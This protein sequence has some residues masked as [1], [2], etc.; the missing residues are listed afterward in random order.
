LLLTKGAHQGPALTDD[1]HAKVLAW[2]QGEVASRGK[3]GGSP[4]TPTVAIRTGDFY[5][6]LDSLVSD[7]LAKLTFSLS[8]FGTGNTYKVSNMTLTAG[9]TA[10]IHIQHPRFVI[11]SAIGATPDPSDALSTIDVST[12]NPSAS[13]PIGTGS[14]LLANLPVSTAR[15]ALAFQVIEKVNANPNAVLTCNNYSAFYPAVSTRL[16]ACAN[17]CHSPTGSDPR[18]SQANGAFNMA[19]ALGTVDADLQK[20]CLYAKGRLNLT[21]LPGSVLI[22]QPEPTAMGG[23]SNHPYKLDATVFPG[24]QS[25]VTNWGKGE[26]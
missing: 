23:T 21:N 3:A 16:A 24:Y 2:L 14:V 6:S 13:V 10:G 19:A 9:P 17:L 1:Q 18:A 12:V 7:P 25:D 26:H 8:L 15:L 4:T 22:L 20:L 11:F 5:I